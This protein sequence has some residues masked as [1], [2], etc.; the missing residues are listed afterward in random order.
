MR[1]ATV[2]SALLLACVLAGCSTAIRIRPPTVTVPNTPEAQACWRQCEQIKA[3]CLPGCQGSLLQ[4]AA[5][6]ACVDACA[7]NRDQ[8]LRGC[9]GSVDSTARSTK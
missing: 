7:D 3:T 6:Q 1:F 8:C 9:P 4:R 2:T 5:V